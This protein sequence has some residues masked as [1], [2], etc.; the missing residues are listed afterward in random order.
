MASARRLTRSAT[1]ARLRDD[2]AEPAIVVG[3]AYPALLTKA[4]LIERHPWTDE[5]ITYHAVTTGYRAPNNSARMCVLSLFTVHNEVVNAWSHYLGAFGALVCLCVSL[6]TLADPG[7]QAIVATLCLSGMF[8]FTSSA[9][10]HT[11]C[12][13]SDMACRSVQVHT[14]NNACERVDCSPLFGHDFTRPSPFPLFCQCCDWLGIAVHTFCTNL[15]VSY[16]ELRH[17]PV[18]F[19]WYNVV[20]LALAVFTYGITYSALQKVYR[21]CDVRSSGA[22]VARGGTSSKKA[23]TKHAWWSHALRPLLAVV[24]SYSFRS[25][26]AMSYALGSLVAWAVG[27]AHTGVVA[28][29]RLSQIMHVYLCFST[30]LLCLFDFPEKFVPPGTCD[31][32]GASHQI[33]HGTCAVSGVCGRIQ[34]TPMLFAFCVQVASSSGSSSSGT[35][36]TPRPSLNKGCRE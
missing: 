24:E 13:Q 15:V 4:E 19:R 16:F 22:A 27:Y 2:A 10:Y 29:G 5:R 26:V 12:C 3:H 18:A 7:A 30:V 31:I 21:S 11:F 35:T 34:L 9:S 6:A 25:L 14:H 23:A 28:W 32:V 17:F 8:M 36:C 1:K 20:N 33:F